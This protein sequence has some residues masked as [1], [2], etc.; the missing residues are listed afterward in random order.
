MKQEMDLDL[1][2]PVELLQWKFG[3]SFPILPLI[4]FIQKADII[5]RM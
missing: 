4:P 2:E 3:G 5:K 1:V